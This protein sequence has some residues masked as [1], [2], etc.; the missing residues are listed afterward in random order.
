MIIFAFNLTYQFMEENRSLQTISI[1]TNQVQIT[2]ALAEKVADYARK[3]LEGALNTQRAYKSDLKYFKEWCIENGQ[4]E[5]PAS[6]S[7]LAAYV[8]YLADTHKWASINRKLAAIS[9]LH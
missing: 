4:S 9:K 3:G 6:A 8:S 1:N 2:E 7:T 5:L